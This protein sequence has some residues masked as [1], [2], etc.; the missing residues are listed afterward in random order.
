MRAWIGRH[1]LTLLTAAF[2][3]AAA[4][5]GL[6]GNAIA[7]LVGVIAAFG[8]AGLQIRAEESSFLEERNRTARAGAELAAAAA[9]LLVDV[10]RLR[11]FIPPAEHGEHKPFTAFDIALWLQSSPDHFDSLHRGD[12]WSSMRDALDVGL[13]A[14]AASVAIHMTSAGDRAREAVERVRTGAQRARDDADRLARLWL[15]VEQTQ[16]EDKQRAGTGASL[17]QIAYEAGVENSRAPLARVPASWRAMVLAAA[18]LI[19]AG[20]SNED[21]AKVRQLDTTVG[22]AK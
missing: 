14:F 15:S 7:T 1:G 8:T 16:R 21:R 3:A 18:Q 5:A 10:S 20:V 6:T 17:S 2:A 22:E 12:G 13:A 9:R 4:A 11:Q 19:G